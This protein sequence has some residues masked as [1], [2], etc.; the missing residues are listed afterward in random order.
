MSPP[1][2]MP[3]GKMSSTVSNVYSMAPCKLH[4]PYR[5]YN[6]SQV[7]KIL[8]RFSVCFPALFEVLAL[9]FAA[10][11]NLGLRHLKD[12]LH[13]HLQPKMVEPRHTG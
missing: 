3:S 6:V 12:Y 5:I 8:P 2:K 4:T 7:L 9:I 10:L 13:P 1:K 11:F